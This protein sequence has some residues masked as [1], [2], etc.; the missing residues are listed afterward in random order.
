VKSSRRRL[1]TA[2]VEIIQLLIANS[3]IDVIGGRIRQVC[4]Q[5]TEL[6]A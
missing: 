5:C 1:K 4:E 6:A 2:L 3:C